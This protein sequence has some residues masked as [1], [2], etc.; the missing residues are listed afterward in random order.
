M[1]RRQVIGF[2]VVLSLIA[3]GLLVKSRTGDAEPADALGTLREAA[4]L[5]PCPSGVG[6]GL[7]DL[8]LP[9][10]GGG[11]AVPLRTA[12]PG[13]PMLVNMWATW[14]RP[15]V[16]EVPV[17]VAFA[18]KAAGK[19]RVLGVDTEDESDKALTFAAQY[20]M[21]YP[22]VVDVDG[23]LLRAYGGGPPVTLFV[24]AGGQVTH[25]EHG[26]VDSVPELEKLVAT[27]LGV[28]L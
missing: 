8:R 12:G 14:C 24:D 23:R 7:P 17:L 4:A 1:T 26:Q 25:V 10:L 27:H 20:G 6:S 11:S 15:C 9:C 5:E 2:V 13:T 21:H 3:V 16:A 22:S 28:R 18:A 19:V